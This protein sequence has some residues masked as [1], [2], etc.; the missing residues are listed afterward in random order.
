MTDRR[1]VTQ[2]VINLYDAYTHITLDRRGYLSKLTSAR[3]Q[4]C[5]APA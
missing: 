3:R 5:W 4:A 2:E 1:M